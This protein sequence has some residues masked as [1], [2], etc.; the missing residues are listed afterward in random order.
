MR[1][2]STLCIL[3]LFHKNVCSNC[4][5]ECPGKGKR[6]RTFKTFLERVKRKGGGEGREGRGGGER[7]EG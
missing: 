6:G 5:K 3:W 1:I 7:E 2:K 4:L